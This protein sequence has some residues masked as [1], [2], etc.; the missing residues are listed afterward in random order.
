MLLPIVRNPPCHLLLFSEPSAFESFA[1]LK[2][3]PKSE[4]PRK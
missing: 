3:V 2:H 4:R 1:R